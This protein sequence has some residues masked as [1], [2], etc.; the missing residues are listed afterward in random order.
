MRPSHRFLLLRASCVTVLALCASCGSPS[1]PQGTPLSFQKLTLGLQHT[2]GLTTEGTV[3]CWGEG[4]LLGTSVPREEALPVRVEGDRLYFDL[5]TGTHTNCALAVA[6]STPYCW[7]RDEDGWSSDTPVRVTTRAFRA[8]SLGLYDGNRCGLTKTGEVYCWGSNVYGQTGTGGRDPV[9]EPTA[10]A[11]SITATQV[12]ASFHACLLN[13][14]GAAYCWGTDIQGQVG[15]SQTPP[16]CDDVLQCMVTTPTAVIGGLTF[17]DISVGGGHSCARTATGEA[18]CWGGNL[19]GEI[20]APAHVV[21]CKPIMPCNPAPTRVPSIAFASIT[22][23]NSATCGVAVSGESY[24]WGNNDE[25]KL[26][27]GNQKSTNV[28]TKISGK[29]AFRVIYPGIRHTCGI[30][31]DD[32]GYCWGNNIVG[33]LGIGTFGGIYTTPKAVAAPR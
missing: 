31:T 7:G 8:L 22:A 9:A 2:C 12:G 13:D 5:A 26:G 15:R 25:G 24:C 21:R 11:A 4:G 1:E 16:S 17:A 19:D 18:Y 33:G 23:G 20:G 14:G 6:D 3:Y 27:T 32:R 10:I 30:T 28:P 29:I